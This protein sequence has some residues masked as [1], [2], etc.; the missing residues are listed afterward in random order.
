MYVH[1]EG[2]CALNFIRKQNNLLLLSCRIFHQCVGYDHFSE[3]RCRLSH[4]H[5]I[6]LIKNR[7]LIHQILM[8]TVSELM[9]QG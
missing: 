2:N 1:V 6:I 3:C 9:S 8:I 5:R 7:E 4:I